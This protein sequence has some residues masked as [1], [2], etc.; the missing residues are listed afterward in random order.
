MLKI[1]LWYL[2]RDTKFGL[3]ISDYKSSIVMTKFESSITTAANIKFTTIKYINF[4]NSLW[5]CIIVADNF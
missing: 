4:K 5:N 2:I 1:Q 3:F